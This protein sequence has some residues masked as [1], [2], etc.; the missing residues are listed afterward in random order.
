ML[1][2]IFEGKRHCKE[3]FVDFQKPPPLKMQKYPPKYNLNSIRNSLP[4]SFLKMRQEYRLHRFILHFVEFEIC[5]NKKIQ[6]SESHN[7]IEINF[8]V[9]FLQAF[10]KFR[11]MIG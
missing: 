8:I 4:L 7:K 6:H 3:E 11:F 2:I 1:Q 10:L 5:N 9:I